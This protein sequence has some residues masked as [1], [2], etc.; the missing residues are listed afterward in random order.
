MGDRHLTFRIMKGRTVRLSLLALLACLA[1][2][3]RNVQA[4]SFCASCEVQ[5]GVG[6]TYHFWGST[7]GVVIPVTVSWDQNR[8]EVGVFR[9]ASQQT[10]LDSNI[11][12]QRLMASPYWG[13][14]ASRRWRLFVRGPVSGFVGFGMA[15]RT[16]ADELSATRWDFAEQL[17]ARVR[18]PGGRSVLELTVRHWSNAGFKLPNH[19]Q[20]FATLT[21]R[22]DFR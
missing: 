10:L 14:S 2:A 21:A 3:P 4:E 8:Y 16:E 1:Y 6:G 22:F 13:V 19:G 7:G 17:G 9:M 18:L 15:I 20:D 12:S 5:I 11:R